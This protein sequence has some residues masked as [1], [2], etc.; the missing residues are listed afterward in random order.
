MSW[1]EFCPLYWLHETP[2]LCK[3]QTNW[4]G[5]WYEL[6]NIGLFMVGLPRGDNGRR[7]PAMAL[8]AP[9]GSRMKDKPAMKKLLIVTTALC[10]LAVDPVAVQA[11]P[12]RELRGVWLSTHLSLD[13]PNRTQTPAQQR[14]ALTSLLD[15]NK[16]TGLNA[17]FFQV[18]SQADAMYQSSLEP[19]SYYL[20]GTQ[21]KAPS[22]VWDPLQFAIEEARKRGLELHAWINP[23]RA[24][25]DVSAANDPL[26]YA[27]NHVSKLHPEWLLTIG[28]V[29]ILN[30][31]LPQVR[32]YVHDVVMDLVQRYDIDGL[33]FDDYFYQS[34]SIADDAAYS[35]DP[36]GFPAT[37]AGRADWRR[38]NVSLLIER[39]GA[40]IRAAKPWVKF[41][42]SPSGIYRSDPNYPG[43]TPDPSL[44]SWTSTGAFQHYNNSYADTRKWLQ[45]G[46]VDYLAPQ[47]YWYIG[48]TG[49]DYQL[50]L[51]WW[52]G[53]SF[54]RHVYIGLAD[55]KMNTSGW[56]A[57]SPDNQIA[58]QIALN[59]GTLPVG[60]QIH[61]R[62]AFLVSNP[63]GY[64]SELMNRV[65]KQPALLPTM[66]WKSQGGAPG[67]PPSLS[68]TRQADG[69][70]SLSWARPAEVSSEFEKVRRYA[71][72]RAEQLPIDLEDP[73]HLLGLTDA[74]EPRFTDTSAAAGSYHHYV[75]TG[76]NRL[77]DESPASPPV[78]D[79]TVPPVVRT[80]ALTRTLVNGEASIGAAE[81]D[82]GSSD[83]WGIAALSLSRNTF[84]CAD[85]GVNAVELEVTDRAGLRSTAAAQVTVLGAVPQPAV[86]ITNSSAVATGFPAN[87]VTLGVGAQSLT[88]TASDT[89]AGPGASRFSW[90]PAPGLSGIDGATAQFVPTAAGT[91]SYRVRA[92]NAYGCSAETTVTLVAVDK[93]RA[94]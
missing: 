82:A 67:M 37:P 74:D 57:P 36:R 46:W 68:A 26:K 33:H 81:V 13:W 6:I 19:W 84:G 72:Y 29:Q 22:P 43:G 86:A 52:S 11:A 45:S 65:Y 28:T 41:G 51:P 9:P 56:T 73:A 31:G 71:I 20:T 79:D 92:T 14:A 55:Y 44:G 5:H 90:T 8:P 88:L 42:I 25:S 47:V 85:I 1:I 32:D 59:R 2:V 60:G 27:V 58:R 40:S 39:I 50:L 18:R 24:V 17:V 75:V 61:F 21:G 35:A 83:N 16:A 49:S 23:Y 91:Y 15:H 89:S 7:R 80:Q 38:D 3:F 64:R 63:L 12:K 94:R 54:D 10:A 30:P 70:V 77:H 69:T 48:Q 76:L 93:R 34:G 78:S 4:Y 66:P 62:Q 87:T 53:N